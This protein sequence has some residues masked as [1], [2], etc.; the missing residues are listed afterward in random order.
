MHA[1]TCTRLAAEHDRDATL[2]ISAP[3]NLR[4]Q[5]L[6][7]AAHRWTLCG[8]RGRDLLLPP[9]A[10]IDY[11]IALDEANEILPRWARSVDPIVLSWA[12]IT[13]TWGCWLPFRS[14]RHTDALSLQH[15]GENTS[16]TPLHGAS[17]CSS[18]YRTV[19]YVARV[20]LP[21]LRRRIIQAPSLIAIRLYLSVV[22]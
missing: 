10:G 2:S 21:L 9:G 12:R 5:N 19:L 14:Y 1:Y 22:L 17:A 11:E 13:G 7:D 8:Q 15:A 20:F 18:R 3:R 16:A 4:Q 6:P